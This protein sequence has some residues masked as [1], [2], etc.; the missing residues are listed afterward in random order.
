MKA[1]QITKPGGVEVLQYVD[2]PIPKP[3][4]DQVLVKNAFAGVNYIDTYYPDS[5][6]PR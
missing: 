1:I 4:K 5:V 6:Y 3:Q 2:V